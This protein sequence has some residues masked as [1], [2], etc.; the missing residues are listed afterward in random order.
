VSVMPQQKPASD[1]YIGAIPKGATGDPRFRV[2]CVT[3]CVGYSD[4]LA[5]TLPLNQHHFDRMVVVTAP[6]DPETLKVCEYYRVEA[7]QTN[8]FMEEAGEFRKAIGINHGLRSLYADPE[9][10]ICHMDADI[11]QP[12][13]FRDSVRN[14]WLDKSMLYGMDRAEF[15]S[16]AEW[17]DFHRLP[18]PQVQGGFLIHTMN[19][20]KPIGTRLQ[21]YHTGGYV[22]IG[23]FQMW[24]SG[25]GQ[26]EYPEKSSNAGAT[27]AHFG[28]KWA[29]AKRGMIP[30]VICY[31]LE[32]EAAP[33]GV[34]WKARETKPF[35]AL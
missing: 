21:F 26:P 5:H 14:A 18:E 27:D 6:W 8:Q 31:H 13:H 7:I 25:L 1:H 19:A 29:R 32:S 30:E 34:N 20:G 22:P 15:K 11:V 33:M 12:P 16:F 9:G 2:S 4:F 23:F 24:H 35:G 10:W 3:I 28:T 17:E